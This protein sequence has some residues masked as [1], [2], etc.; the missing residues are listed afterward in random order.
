M[1][2]IRRYAGRVWFR[3]TP[4]AARGDDDQHEIGFRLHPVASSK[5]ATYHQHLAACQTLTAAANKVWRCQI[6]TGKVAKLRRPRF[7]AVVLSGVGP[8]LVECRTA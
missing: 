8:G 2:S 6:C 4:R 3:N 7:G 1:C 5:Q